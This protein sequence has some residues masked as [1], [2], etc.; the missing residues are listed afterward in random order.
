[1]ISLRLRFWFWA[2][3]V[4]QFVFGFGS[5]PYLWAVERASDATDWG[6]TAFRAGRDASKMLKLEGPNCGR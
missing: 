1:M 2:M 3:D 4:T 6:A 5:A